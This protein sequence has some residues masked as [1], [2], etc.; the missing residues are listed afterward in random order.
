MNFFNLLI[1]LLI[2]YFLTTQ[3][4]QTFFHGIWEEIKFE[5]CLSLF[6]SEKHVLGTFYSK[7]QKLKC[8]HYIGFARFFVA[9][10]CETL[11]ILLREEQRPE[12]MRSGEYLDPRGRQ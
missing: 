4:F 7:T 6:S 2:E 5:E 1:Y 8:K 12:Y 3:I 9:Y 11:A 10:G